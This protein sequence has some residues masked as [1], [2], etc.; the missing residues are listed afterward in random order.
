MKNIPDYETQ[1]YAATLGKI[2]GVYLGRPFEG[3][4]KDDIEKKWGAITRYV[5]EDRGVPLVVADDD[6]SGTFTFVKTLADSGLFEKTP[7][8][9]FGESWLN[10]LLENQTILWWG[11]CA[12]S[13]E[14]T[15]FL[16]LKEGIKAP[17]SGSIET[18]G[19]E[20]AEQIGA[21]IFIDA[22]GMVAPGNPALAVE[23][24]KMAAEVSHGGEAVLAA[25]VVAAMVSIAFTVKDIHAVMDAAIEFIP[26]DSLI[27]QVHRDVR[28]W[29]K[30]DGDWRKT[31]DRIDAKYGYGIYGGNCH[32]IPNHAIMVMAWAYSDNDFFKAQSI[33]NTAGWDT[34]CNAA[35]VGS[36]SALVA[37]IDHLCDTYDFRGPVADRVMIPTADGTDTIT[38]ALRL[39]Q[40]I[41]A[42]GRAIAGEAPSAP[43]KNGALLHFEAPGATHGF[44]GASDGTSA[45]N[46]L[47]PSDACAP[48]QFK[49]ARCLAIKFAAAPESPALATTPVFMSQ[50]LNPQH[51]KVVA[52]PWLYSGMKVAASVAL[53]DDSDAVTA[54]MFARDVAG[55]VFRSQPA[56][57]APDASAAAQIEWQISAGEDP[58]LELGF[59]IS[60][61]TGKPAN[62]TLLVDWVGISGAAELAYETVKHHKSAHEIIGWIS[63]LDGVRGRFSNEA[64][65][66]QHLIRNDGLGVMATGNRSWV[67]ARATLRHS[68]HSAR[69]A[70]FLLRYQGLRRHYA[71]MFER[72]ADGKNM[73]RIT[74]MMYGE[75]LLA[76]TPFECEENRDYAIEVS[77]IGDTIS[78]SID[79]V[80][81]LEAKDTALVSGGF[82]LALQR[83]V[84]GFRELKLSAT[85]DTALL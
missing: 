70:G 45:F 32:V 62:G 39:S 17:A 68:I 48:T 50:L 27:A 52:T 49:G 26:A 66:F 43:P 47:L 2:I 78:I 79:G 36:V 82:A 63:N 16:N 83:G 72:G 5:H 74:R 44:M 6:I 11:G 59:E 58:L 25:Q 84:S 3:W 41:A 13:T 54:R 64:E 55:N 4:S 30:A 19:R 34:D 31:Y 61:A 73:L 53:S 7:P 57:L 71:A 51:Y 18:N 85:L 40:K 10:Y 9:I 29:A 22:F 21:Q 80:K 33:I 20:V 23:L 46:A 56:A 38:D 69:R 28:A 76:E 8:E 42:I 75:T 1:V 14:H 60:S 35:N 77:A 67:D 65:D 24:A 81:I 12:H 37:G 15:A